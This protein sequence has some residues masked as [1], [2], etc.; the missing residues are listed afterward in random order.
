MLISVDNSTLTVTANNDVKVYINK[1]NK[2][3]GRVTLR[4]SSTST[5][6]NAVITANSQSKIFEYA[7]YT[8]KSKVIYTETNNG[9]HKT[10]LRISVNATTCL[11]PV[12]KN[13]LIHYPIRYV[14]KINNT[15]E[16]HLINHLHEIILNANKVAERYWN[17]YT[18]YHTTAT[19][20]TVTK[21]ILHNKPKWRV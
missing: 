13:Y 14:T 3:C 18:Y 6:S 21:N 20:G 17:L 9:W 2:R 1:A 15:L 7:Y 12:E 4:H 19:V 11:E 16:R 5:N 10:T 8:H